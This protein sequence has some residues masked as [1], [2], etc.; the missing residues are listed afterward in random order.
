TDTP[1]LAWHTLFSTEKQPSSGPGQWNDIVDAHDGSVLKSW[2]GIHTLSEASGPGGNAKYSHPWMNNLDVEL[3]SGT[4]FVMDT[5]RLRTADMMH[6][7]A[8]DG[9]S[10]TGSLSSFISAVRSRVVS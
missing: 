8:G 9:T 5:T 10:A 2:N 6:G 1:H 3:Q 4:T 7:T